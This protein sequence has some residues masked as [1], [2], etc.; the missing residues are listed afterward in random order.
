MEQESRPGK[1]NGEDD[2]GEGEGE[3]EVEDEEEQDD[4]S[5]LSFL[6]RLSRIPRATLSLE[7]GEVFRQLQRAFAFLRDGEQGCYD[8][9]SL[10]RACSSLKLEHPVESQNDASEL[11][12]LLQDRVEETAR[13]MRRRGLLAAN[14]EGDGE[15]EGEGEGDRDRKRD[16]EKGQGVDAA[17]RSVF[18]G[19]TLKQKRCLHPGCGLVTTKAVLPFLQLSLQCRYVLLIDIYIYI[20]V[21]VY[22]LHVCVCVCVCSVCRVGFVCVCHGACV[23]FGCVCRAVPCVRA[24]VRPLGQFGF[25][26]CQ[27]RLSRNL[28][29]DVRVALMG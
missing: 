11:F 23:V 20:Y 15:K 27:R 8:P 29:K 24:C 9:F 3:V 19:L 5:P 22:V 12:D 14:G 7:E 4:S 17:L 6:S 28:G 13:A 10:V 18:S 25:R 2:E 1:G 26:V 21:Y 16:K